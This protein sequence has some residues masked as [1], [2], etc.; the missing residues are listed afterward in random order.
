MMKNF[1]A[2]L[3]VLLCLA[4]VFCAAACGDTPVT[5]PETPNGPAAGTTRSARTDVGSA[6][7]TT[8]VADGNNGGVTSAV[9]GNNGGAQGGNNGG[10]NGGAQ[11]GNNGGKV[12]GAGSQTSAQNGG[13]AV[14]S[15]AFINSLKGL[16]INIWEQ[17][18]EKMERGTTSGDRYYAILNK[19]GKKYGATI[20][21]KAKTDGD[22]K[23]SI[24]S[25]NPE[26]N[27][28]S[29]KDYNIASWINSGVCANLNDAMAQT[30]I[31]FSSPWYDQEIVNFC[32]FDGKQMCWNA[33]VR[34]PFMISYNK[35][36]IQEARLTDPYTLYEQ[37][38]WDYKT[39]ETYVDKLTKKSASD[40]VLIHG[41]MSG[42]GV[43]LMM[44]T[45]GSNGT[46]AVKASKGKLV[47]NLTDKKVSNA[48][49]AFRTIE[50]KTNHGTN[51]DSCMIYFAQGK[52]AMSLA[53]KY[54]FTVINT[55]GMTDAVGVVPF[56]SGPDAKNAKYPVTQSFPTFIAKTDEKD[57]A[58][59]LYVMDEVYKEHYAYREQDFYDDFRSLI[60]DEK[61]YNTFK[62]FSLDKSK[63]RVVYDPLAGIIWPPAPQAYHNLSTA[64][65][66]NTVAAA[67]NTHNKSFNTALNDVWGGVTITNLK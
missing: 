53:T 44:M 46:S 11:N 43:D 57:A 34:E 19:V 9:G 17:R 58:K 21:Y 22:L 60:R 38:K 31:N 7:G 50:S 4:F 26:A 47:S 48:L 27:V 63:T 32:K 35:R 66:K 55:Y 16:K 42:T 59:I 40:E 64:L 23:T 67:V 3:A 28:I 65:A 13:A 30:G 62:T 6:D 12:T 36:M 52:S 51:W 33:T 20:T 39:F 25:G 49:N 10:N 37:G 45:I 54:I 29:L 14:G 61:A 24:L 5:D 1:K 2:L 8:S 18:S 56:P 15:T 41:F